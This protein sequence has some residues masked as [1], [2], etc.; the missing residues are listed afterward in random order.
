MFLDIIKTKN[1]CSLIDIKREKKI[2]H[3]LRDSI[4]KEAFQKDFMSTVY[5][6]LSRLCDVC[7]I[8]KVG[9][10]FEDTFR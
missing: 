2:N 9:K 8:I 1:F 3:R 4:F 6:E 7:V 5:K 10:R